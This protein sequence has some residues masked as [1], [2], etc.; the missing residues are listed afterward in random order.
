MCFQA[1]TRAHGFHHCNNG[2]HYTLV[3]GHAHSKSFLVCTCAVSGTCWKRIKQSASVQWF[4]N[5]NDTHTQTHIARSSEIEEAKSIWVAEP[6]LSPPSTFFS[7]FFSFPPLSNLSFSGFFRLYL[8][9]LYTQSA[10]QKTRDTAEKWEQDRESVKM[11]VS[12]RGNQM[13]RVCITAG[14]RAYVWVTGSVLH[15]FFS[16]LLCAFKRQSLHILKCLVD[17]DSET[18]DEGI[19]VISLPTLHRLRFR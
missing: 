8:C 4:K 2:K 10:T 19:S 17:S 6:S 16:G 13:C 1:Q 5:R 15:V 9:F 3:H 7:P 11:K 12:T 14:P 18:L